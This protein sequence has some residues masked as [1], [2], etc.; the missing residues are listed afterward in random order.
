VPGNLELVLLANAPDQLYILPFAKSATTGQNSPDNT[1][2]AFLQM[3]DRVLI[4]RGGDKSDVG[5][6]NP[7]SDA[8]HALR[9]GERD[10]TLLRHSS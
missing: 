5:V 10:S 7:E 3:D 2:H 9:V 8:W 4:Y 6:I 1:R